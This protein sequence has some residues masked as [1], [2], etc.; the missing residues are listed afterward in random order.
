MPYNP[1]SDFVGLWRAVSGG[2]EK[3][4]MPGMDFVVAALERAGL[5]R[6]V[7][8]QTA[9]V[10]NQSTTAWFK[11]LPSSFSGE[12][13][14]F[15]WDPSLN[16]YVPATPELFHGG[17]TGGGGGGGDGGG[18][19]GDSDM[20]IISPTPPVSPVAGQ[21]WWDG[22][23]MQVWDGAVWKLIGPPAGPGGAALETSTLVFAITQSN[24]L[25]VTA[26]TWVIINYTDSPQVDTIAGSWDP[27]TKKYTAK[28]PGFYAVQCR[29]WPGTGTGGVAIL[30]NDDGIFDNNNADITISMDLNSV[31]AMGLAVGFVQMN[32][33]TDYVRCFGYNQG[34]LLNPVGSSPAFSV[35]RLS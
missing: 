22:T 10:V 26:S 33:T 31:P 8:S 2:V 27:V 17:S 18:G 11:P 20:A 25:T 35:L 21:Q 13:S 28:K 30:K 29:T 24:P 7:T 4:Q 9:P 15:L 5:L 14:L 23:K 3:A 32:G 34:A 6:V 19:T 12:G 16:M 1:S